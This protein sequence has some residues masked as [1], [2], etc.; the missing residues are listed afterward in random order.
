MSTEINGIYML[1]LRKEQLH[2]REVPT[3][4]EGNNKSDLTAGSST[5]FKNWSS[6]L[7]ICMSL[8]DH[9]LID[10]MENVKRQSTP[11]YD[12][13]FI[14]HKPDKHQPE[15]TKQTEEKRQNYRGS[16]MTTAVRVELHYRVLGWWV[17]LLVVKVGI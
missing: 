10:I 5:T 9:N 14:D 2:R 8:E 16:D 6:E 13:A 12:D 7:Q 11:I 4:F 17:E 1:S 15:I 3:I